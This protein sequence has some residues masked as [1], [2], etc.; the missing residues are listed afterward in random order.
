MGI[1]KPP[2]LYVLWVQV[3]AGRFRTFY[4]EKNFTF[5]L[6]HVLSMYLTFTDLHL[7]VFGLCRP[8]G[9]GL[10]KG[11]GRRR[12]FTYLSMCEKKFTFFYSV[13]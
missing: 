7:P 10:K 8:T 13:C 4:I 5:F 9:R 6:Y 12:S 11:A 1:E 2:L 3:S